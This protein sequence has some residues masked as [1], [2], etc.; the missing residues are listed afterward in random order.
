[1]LYGSSAFFEHLG[2]HLVY[3]HISLEIRIVARERII[4]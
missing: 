3:N 2:Y 4:T 1:V